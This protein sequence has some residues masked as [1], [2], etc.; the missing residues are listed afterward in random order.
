MQVYITRNLPQN[1]KEYLKEMR[2]QHNYN[3]SGSKKEMILKITQKTTAYGLNSI[4]HRATN[5]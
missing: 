4:Y 5:D 2:N 3:T 1:F